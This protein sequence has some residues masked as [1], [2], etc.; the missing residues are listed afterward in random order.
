MQVEALLLAICKFEQ[1]CWSLGQIC[2]VNRATCRDIQWT[3]RGINREEEDLRETQA[4][5]RWAQL[6]ESWH[7]DYE[8]QSD[9]S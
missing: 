1:P 5:E 7:Y 4:V 8:S 6:T 3:L 9:S 2:A